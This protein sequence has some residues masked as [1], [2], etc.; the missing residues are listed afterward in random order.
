MDL[1]HFKHCSQP[2][3]RRLLALL[4]LCFALNTFAHAGHSHDSKAA[5]DVLCGYCSTF[6]HT[7]DAPVRDLVA[8]LQQVVFEYRNPASIAVRSARPLTSAQPR[9]PPT[10]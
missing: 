1:P 10:H 6:A 7:A 4:M 2:W 5:G 9:A 8:P 3:L